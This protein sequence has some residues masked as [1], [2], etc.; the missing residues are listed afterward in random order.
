MA[1]APVSQADKQVRFAELGLEGNLHKDPHVNA[2]LNIAAA[3]NRNG[4]SLSELVEN[5]DMITSLA[6]ADHGVP[7]SA[8]TSQ[9]M[10]DDPEGDESD[11]QDELTDGASEPLEQT[12]A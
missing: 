7:G 3:I 2:L 1:K 6:L 10:D 8:R 11:P 4:K 9:E 12:Q 5:A